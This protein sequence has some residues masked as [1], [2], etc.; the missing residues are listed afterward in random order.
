MSTSVGGYSRSQTIVFSSALI[1][2]RTIDDYP[3]DRY[4]IPAR[5][6]VVI[7]PYLLQ[8][9]GRFV[10]DPDRFMPER[11]IPEFKAS[12]LPFACFPFGG[13]S[14]RCIGE[15]FAWMELVLPVSTLARHWRF[16]LVPGHPVIPQSV[17][18]FQ[19][20]HGLKM[21]VTRRG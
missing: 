18:T 12:L 4:L 13:G 7:S 10:S 6:I 16:T 2:R 19:L 14:R 17:V 3:V 15:S 20:K 11:W 1:G 21:V 5:S 9:D 8:R